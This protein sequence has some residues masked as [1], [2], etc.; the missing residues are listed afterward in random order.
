[1]T[2]CHLIS[3]LQQPGAQEEPH[4]CGEGAGGGKAGAERARGQNASYS[5]LTDDGYHSTIILRAC[6]VDDNMVHG[7]RNRDRLPEGCAARSE[8]DGLA[9][10]LEPF[11]MRAAPRQGGKHGCVRGVKG[12]RG[13]ERRSEGGG[14]ESRSERGGEERRSGGRGGESRTSDASRTSRQTAGDD[15]D[16]RRKTN[17]H[18]Y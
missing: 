16:Q 10:Q 1:M 6:A 11:S 13:E 9:R 5:H 7:Q 2:R 14:E 17:R 8:E 18:T 15:A 12:G 4:T 3:S